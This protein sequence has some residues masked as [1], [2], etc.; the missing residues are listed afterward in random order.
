MST[1]DEIVAAELQRLSA[2]FV[3]QLPEQVQAAGELAMAWLGAPRDAGRYA[4]LSHR[5]HQL[6][7]AGSTFGCPGISRAARELERRIAEYRGELEAGRL[8]AAEDVESAIAELQNEA[9][10]V[11]TESGGPEASP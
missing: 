4:I 5:V 7:G 1:P 10:R 8:P 6:K 2:A 3:A 9:R 11:R